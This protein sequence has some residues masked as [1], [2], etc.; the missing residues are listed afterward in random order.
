MKSYK[1]ILALSLSLAFISPQICGLSGVYASSMEASTIDLKVDTGKS[2]FSQKTIS[3]NQNEANKEAALGEIRKIRA[4]AWDENFLYTLNANSNAKKERIQDLAKAYGYSSKEAYINALTWS[5]DLERIAIQRAF[6][7]TITGLDHDRADGSSFQS[8]KTD[9][10]IYSEAEILAGSTTKMDAARAF[11]QWSFQKMSYLNGKSEY[12]TLLESDGVKDLATNGHLHQ[13]LNPEMKF[14]GFATVNDRNSQWNY[15]V[16]ELSRQ[17]ANNNPKAE[18]LSG[19][20]KLFVG[21]AKDA[22]K[23]DYEDDKLEK[24]RQAVKEA[25]NQITVAENLL[26]NYPKTVANVKDKLVVMIENARKLIQR[27]EII[28]NK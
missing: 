26:N 11:D 2:K 10:G 28:L 9:R 4:K 19:I 12:D 24:L 27:A 5:N 13:I 1:K 3:L 15:A 20:Y 21:N 16:G 25:Q 14:V 7:Q 18:N 8:A 23:L 17:S 6:E 22:P